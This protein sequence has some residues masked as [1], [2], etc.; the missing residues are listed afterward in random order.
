MQK[1]LLESE[2]IIYVPISME[3]INDYLTMVN[4]IN[5]AKFISNEIRTFSYEEEEEWI[6]SK[7]EQNAV[8]FTMLEKNTNKFIGNI[9]LLKFEGASAEMG[10][11]ITGEM[12][13]KHFGYEGMKTLI[14]YGFNTLKLDEIRL[15]VLSN[16]LR[17][18]HCYK[19]LG[20][21]EYKVDKDVTII[22]NESVDDIYMKIKK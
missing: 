9:E 3:F 12:Q 19:K 13:N 11:T 17:A 7:L 8:I 4:D 5:V 20:F 21:I 6:Q 14:E 10:I 1:Y 15:I 22:D 16:N 18:I 2:N